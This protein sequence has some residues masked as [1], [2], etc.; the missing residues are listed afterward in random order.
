MNAH[1]SGAEGGGRAGR[2]RVRVVLTGACDGLGELRD[3]LENHPE[4]D[5]PGWCEDVRYAAGILGQAQPAVVLHATRESGL[6]ASDIATIREHTQAPIILL[7][8]A[9][10]Y[11][12]LDHAL[13][14]D[15]ADVLL[16]PQYVDNVVFAV[17]KARQ[18]RRAATGR[19]IVVQE[20]I[21]PA[22]Q[23]QVITVF[24]PKGG[25]GRSVVATSL[26]TALVK[27]QGRK[28][29]LLD[30]DLQ[31]GDAAIMLGAEPEKTV[32]D[33]VSSPGEVDS[34]KLAAY[35]MGV[36]PGVD[37]LAAPIRPEDA[38]FVTEAKV[39]RLLEAAKESY[40][41]VVVDTPPFFHGPVLAALD[42]TDELLL[43]CGLDV[44]TLKNV[45]LSL[46]TLELLSF[47]PERIRLV[48]NQAVPRRSVKR[49]EVE[50]ALGVKVSFEIPYDA[51]VPAA[52][53]RG[54]P[55]VLNGGLRVIRE[56]AATLAPGGRADGASPLLPVGGQNGAEQGRKSR[57]PALG[58][59]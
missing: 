10:S 8:S 23:G 21:A 13:D 37:L 32:F 58:R 57:W 48:V 49:S 6:P 41:V 53:N 47:A 4:L 2:E 14:A 52:V 44:P 24:G 36:G 27:Y 25:A 15:V 51:D 38:E 43:L 59:A 50:A 16:L 17:R 54:V 7:A 31:F 42:Q 45:R 29:V 3:A 20:T 22:G 19:P 40:D 55:P 33:L 46:Q 35:T 56:I 5:L 39:A 1:Y 9:S 12:L 34:E 28:T 30:L 26:A 18:T 11:G